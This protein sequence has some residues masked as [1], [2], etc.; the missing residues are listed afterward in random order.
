[1]AMSAA[2]DATRRL[3]RR[4][5]KAKRS[6]PT[7]RKGGGSDGHGRLPRRGETIRMLERRH[8]H[9]PKVFAWRGNRYDVQAVERCWTVS[10]G[11]LRRA[12]QRYC[13]RVRARPQG[14]GKPVAERFEIYQDVQRNS[15]HLQRRR[16]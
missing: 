7:A 6:R 4:R 15:W 14:E 5:R 13:F 10:R 3:D 8:G 11:G 1:M 12:V 16:G 9:F 2:L